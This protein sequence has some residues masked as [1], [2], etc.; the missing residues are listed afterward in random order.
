MRHLGYVAL[1]LFAL[2]LVLAGQRL[3]Q[4]STPVGQV[5][6][7]GLE[8]ALGVGLMLALLAGCGALLRR[9]ARTSRSSA[10]SPTQPSVTTP[11]VRYRRES[12]AKEKCG[13][14]PL[15]RVQATSGFSLSQELGE[16]HPGQR[17]GRTPH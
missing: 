6:L 8:V 17:N 3:G 4:L 14:E 7:V 13:E 16:R 5:L 15:A 11:L 1:A 10:A 12:P 2:G 9:L